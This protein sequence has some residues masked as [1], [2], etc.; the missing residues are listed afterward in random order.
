[1]LALAKHFNCKIHVTAAQYHRYRFVPD[2]VNILTRN[3]QST[4]IHFCQQD[5]NF[6]R[7]DRALLPCGKELNFLP[8][9]LQIIPSV[10]YFTKSRVTP[11]EMVVC[12]S[13]TLVRV[14][15]SSHSSYEEIVD[16]LSALKPDFIYPSVR[17]NSHLTLEDVIRSLS[18][19][20]S[21]SNVSVSM[22]SN[23]NRTVMFLKSGKSRFML[24]SEY[25]EHPTLE[26][27]LTEPGLSEEPTNESVAAEVRLSRVIPD[28]LTLLDQLT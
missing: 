25:C 13:E 4:N 14:C 11:K 8:N 22:M 20:E 17:P 9:V 26:D 24:N 23:E 10:M 1:M 28:A 18:F 16:F 21:R 7:F 12:E 3:A 27:T 15:Y 5:S 2:I 6:G 19:L